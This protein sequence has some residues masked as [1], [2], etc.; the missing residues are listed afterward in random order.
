[1]KLDDV[2]VVVTGGASG[3]G[4][5]TAQRLARRGARVALLDRDADRLRALEKS[6]RLFPFEC[7][8]T[9]GPGLSQALDVVTRQLGPPAVAVGCAGVADAGRA[10]GREGPLALDRFERVLAV[11]LVGM[12]N[13]VRLSAARMIEREPDPTS[14]ERGVLV[15]T[16]SIAAFDGQIGQAAYAASKAG[17]V[18]MTLP[19]ARELATH[20][21]RVMSIA[22]GLF[23]TPMFGRLRPDLQEAMAKSVPFPSRLGQPDEYA[24]LVEH[25]VE[26]PMLNGEVVRLDGALRLSLR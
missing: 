2:T 25:I 6:E 24:A 7:D 17:V 1:M 11:N 23:D 12:F 21:V 10:V 3:L 15:M 5:A 19:L 13:L 9:D 8:V 4:L 14:G 22:P 18:G 16:A 20:G 26:N